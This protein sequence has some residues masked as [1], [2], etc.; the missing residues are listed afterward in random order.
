MFTVGYK[1]TDFKSWIA[2]FAFHI[3][4]MPFEKLWIQL[5]SHS[6]S[7]FP[8]LSLSIYGLIIRQIELFNV[9]MT[10]SLVE[11]KL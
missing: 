5:F 3:A 4:L 10:T 7:L 8:P 11:R 1:R 9:S 2:Q 6:L